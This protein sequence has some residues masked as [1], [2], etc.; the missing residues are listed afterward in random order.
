MS[1]FNSLQ[2]RM[3]NE[4]SFSPIN[5]NQFCYKL[6]A[7]RKKTAG[8][9]MLVQYQLSKI[10]VN[11]EATESEKTESIMIKSCY[12]TSRYSMMTHPFHIWK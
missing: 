12:V 11:C 3:Q 4:N 1:I 9:I 7:I 8:I 2:K 6:K 10:Q 5:F